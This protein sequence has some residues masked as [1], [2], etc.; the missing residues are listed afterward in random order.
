M[1]F[2]KLAKQR[3]VV[4]ELRR[5]ELRL[6]LVEAER[7][8]LEVDHTLR[9]RAAAWAATPGGQ[10]RKLLDTNAQLRQELSEREAFVSE[11]SLMRGQGTAVRNAVDADRFIAQLQILTAC[12]RKEWSP[13]IRVVRVE[14]NEH[15]FRR[16]QHHV[17]SRRRGAGAHVVLQ[18]PD[19]VAVTLFYDGI[20]VDAA[21]RPFGRPA[22][23][24]F[25]HAVM[26]GY[27]PDAYR[28][29]HPHGVVF[30]PIVDRRSETFAAAPLR[31]STKHG[32]VCASSGIVTSQR[33]AAASEASSTIRNL[34]VCA[35]GGRTKLHLKV[36]AD[37][38]LATVR[39]MLAEAWP[40]LRATP[41]DAPLKLSS[42]F[43]FE[44]SRRSSIT[45]TLRGDDLDDLA[46]LEAQ[47]APRSPTLSEW[48]VVD[49]SVLRVCEL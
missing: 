43:V 7:E 10:L 18:H 2:E 3:C 46:T 8:E 9:I 17:D 27:N 37:D 29:T 4:L 31:A 30:A 34:R 47:L 1:A 49:R 26:S 16:Q 22:G 36:S 19:P 23:D 44:E 15:N 12:A 41:A 39:A 38:T 6:S 40:A 33:A 20:L 28:A 45:W 5:R 24:T 42:S 32:E 11:H 25:V 21:F 13:V 48:G 35:L 14:R